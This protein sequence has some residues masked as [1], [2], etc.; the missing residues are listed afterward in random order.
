MYKVHIE[1]S[2]S[3]KPEVKVANCWQS[4]F[5]FCHIYGLIVKS[6]LPPVMH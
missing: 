2:F 4:Q 5:C 1:K 6:I 3:V